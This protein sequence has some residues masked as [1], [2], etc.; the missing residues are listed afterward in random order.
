VGM[1]IAAIILYRAA[2]WLQSTA[3]GVPA[4]LTWR[5]R[6]SWRRPAAPVSTA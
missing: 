1:N 4:Y 2:T 3:L 5:Y 6:R